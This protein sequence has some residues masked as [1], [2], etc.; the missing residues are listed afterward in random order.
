VS[1]QINIERK[2]FGEDKWGNEVRTTKYTIMLGYDYKPLFPRY[3]FE[4]MEN[5]D[6]LKMIRLMIEKLS[7]ADLKR[8]KRDYLNGIK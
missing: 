8:F 6:F 5:S 4:G 3:I 1:T 7:E 2:D